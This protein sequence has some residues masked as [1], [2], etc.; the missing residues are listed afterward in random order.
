MDAR[1]KIGLSG[2]FVTMAF[3]ITGTIGMAVDNDISVIG[4][5]TNEC[6]Y[7]YKLI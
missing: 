4:L 5:F 2:S 3:S 1:Q 6:L 7:F